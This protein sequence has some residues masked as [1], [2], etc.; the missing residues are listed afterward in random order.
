[1]GKGKRKEVKA[2]PLSRYS[3]VAFQSREKIQAPW[4]IR[5]ATCSP[6]ETS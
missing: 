2:H 5:L 1:M 3:P 6:E 4:P